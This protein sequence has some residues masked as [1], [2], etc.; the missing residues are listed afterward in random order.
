MYC[1][2]TESYSKIPTVTVMNLVTLVE[3]CNFYLT[4]TD[5]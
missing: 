3:C 5:Q 2:I 4:E 1:S